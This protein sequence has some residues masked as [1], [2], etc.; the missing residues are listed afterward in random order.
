MQSEEKDTS[1]CKQRDIHP[2]TGT[3]EENVYDQCRL[4]ST[5]AWPGI[6]FPAVYVCMFCVCVCG[7]SIMVNIGHFPRVSRLPNSTSRP[8]I[9]RKKRQE[10]EKQKQS[11]Q[12]LRLVVT[13]LFQKITIKSTI[14]GRCNQG[15][16][17]IMA[18]RP[19]NQRIH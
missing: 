15:R 1:N 2:E 19:L 18:F 16:G 8:G 4:W 17:T 14:T 3:G 9:G 5:Q 10:K 7:I 11:L 12:P 6:I 13:R